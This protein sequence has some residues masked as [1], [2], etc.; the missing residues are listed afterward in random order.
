MDG[1]DANGQA[2]AAWFLDRQA[3]A[4]RVLLLRSFGVDQLWLADWDDGVAD[5]LKAPAA[6]ET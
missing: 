3:L 1:T 2:L 5:L 6:P 4:E